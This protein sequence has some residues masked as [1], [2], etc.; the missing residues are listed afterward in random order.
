[1]TPLDYL[2]RY[3]SLDE[4]KFLPDNSSFADFMAWWYEQMGINLFALER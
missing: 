3:K 4:I 2:C 1:M